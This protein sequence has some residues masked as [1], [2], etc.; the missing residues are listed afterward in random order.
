M[1]HAISAFVRQQATHSKLQKLPYIREDKCTLQHHADS[2]VLCNSRCC[3]HLDPCA[4]P[5]CAECGKKP[6]DRTGLE[7]QRHDHTMMV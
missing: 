7:F 3:M 2:A 4:R 5:L 6:C 1:L